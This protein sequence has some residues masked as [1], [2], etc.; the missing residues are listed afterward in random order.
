MRSNGPQPY[1]KVKAHHYKNMIKMLRYCVQ[2]SGRWLICGTQRLVKKCFSYV[3][4]KSKGNKN[5][6]RNAIGLSVQAI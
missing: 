3:V 1:M 4:V 2:Y 5:F 6:K